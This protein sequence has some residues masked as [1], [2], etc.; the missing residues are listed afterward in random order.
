MSIAEFHVMTKWL[1]SVAV[2]PCFTLQKLD[3]PLLSVTVN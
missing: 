2:K 1:R 3:C